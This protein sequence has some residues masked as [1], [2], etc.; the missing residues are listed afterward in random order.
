MKTYWL[1]VLDRSVRTVAQSALS[2]IGADQV[3]WLSLDWAA[4][5]KISAVAGLLSVLMSM[6]TGGIGRQGDPGIV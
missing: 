5:G 6:M 2:L 4:I 3:G 1:K